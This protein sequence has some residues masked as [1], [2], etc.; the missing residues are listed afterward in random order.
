[1]LAFVSLQ[2]HLEICLK[3]ITMYVEFKIEN[4]RTILIL[5]YDQ[6]NPSFP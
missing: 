4:F 3:K 1:M 2:Y 6:S 5:E